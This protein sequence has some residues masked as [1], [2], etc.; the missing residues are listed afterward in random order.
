[1]NSS[2]SEVVAIYVTYTDDEWPPLF[3]LFFPSL[4]GDD[5]KINIKKKKRRRDA[6]NGCLERNY[7]AI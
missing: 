4:L 3:G 5:V 1:M 7:P 2:N 6:I